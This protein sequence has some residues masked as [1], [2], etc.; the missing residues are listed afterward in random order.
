MRRLNKG[1]DELI[2]KTEI[3]LQMKKTKLRLLRVRRGRD[4]LGN[5]DG[6]TYI[7]LYIK[8]ITNKDLPYSTGNWEKNLKKSGYMYITDS[9]CC[10]AKTNTTVLTNSTPIKMKKL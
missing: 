9:L 5:W 6:Y 1:T 10:T 3:E 8:Q 2:R 7:L 4:K